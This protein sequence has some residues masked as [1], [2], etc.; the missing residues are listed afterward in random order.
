MIITLYSLVLRPYT[1]IVPYTGVA[2]TGRSGSGRAVA[3]LQYK[4]F[5]AVD[6]VRL[7]LPPQ[8]AMPGPQSWVPPSQ[9]L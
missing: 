8:V 2:Y 9:G 7:A 5:F 6:A 4:R 3:V 1:L